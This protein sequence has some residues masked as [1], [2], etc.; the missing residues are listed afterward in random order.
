MNIIY[1]CKY[2]NKPIIEGLDYCQSCRNIIINFSDVVITCDCSED[3]VMALCRECVLINNQVIEKW[4]NEINLMDS[5]L[6]RY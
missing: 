4:K 3:N 1:R 5:N 6:N 2:C